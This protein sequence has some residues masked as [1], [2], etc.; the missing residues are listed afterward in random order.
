M[1]VSRIFL[2][3]SLLLVPLLVTL[4]GCSCGFDCSGSNSNNNNNNSPTSLTLGFSD[5]L[6]E[7]LNEVVITVTSITF[8]RSG[9]EDVVVD[10]FTLTID[11]KDMVDVADFQMDLLDYRG[12]NQLEVIENLE[13]DTGLY[14]EVS[15]EVEGDDIN[16]S[17]VVEID[18]GESKILNVPGGSLDLKDLQLSSGSQA[19]TVEFSLA[20]ALAFQSSDGSYLLTTTGIRME[21]NQKAASL[22]G[23]IDS[24]L[25]DTV[26]PCSEKSDPLKGNRIYLYEGKT[27]PSD[28]LV[29]V[30][31]SESSELPP[32]AMVPFAVASLVFNKT[33]QSWDY[34]FGYI[35]AGEYTMAFSCNT[36]EDDSVEWN[37]LTIPLPEGQVYNNI[38]LTEGEKAQCNLSEGASC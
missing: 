21:D 24:T 9:A 25:F 19:V 13:L 26:S 17:Y 30:F 31:T 27:L 29:D 3:L 28:S 22:S 4:G 20:Q 12:L 1:H 8:R 5:S 6:P 36:E 11:D 38:E 10:N 32:D 14:S 33:T 23:Q 35:P 2:S 16:N 34:S 7:D 18:N 37:D 15:I